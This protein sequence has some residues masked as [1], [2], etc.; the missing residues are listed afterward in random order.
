MTKSCPA[1][2]TSIEIGLFS[3]REEIIRCPKC[4]ELLGENPKR[5]QIGYLITLI[6][7]LIWSGCHFWL[8][9]SLLSG[10]LTILIFILL[11]FL[12]TDFIIIKKELTIRNKKTNEVSYID[13]SDWDEILKNSIDRENSFEI[14][15][16]LK[17]GTSDLS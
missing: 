4:G 10:L 3:S 15:E 5:K 12:I 16:E 11:S 17:K 1:C 13:K 6:G 2:Q 14:I 9:F 7:M 8:G